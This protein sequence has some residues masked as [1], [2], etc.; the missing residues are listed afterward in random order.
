MFQPQ[1]AIALKTD[2]GPEASASEAAQ[3]FGS[4]PNKG[5]E[6]LNHLIIL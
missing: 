4:P 6:F 5:H 2:P 3:F 1:F